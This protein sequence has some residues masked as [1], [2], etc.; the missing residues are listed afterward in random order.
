[1]HRVAILVVLLMGALGVF[2]PEA[3]GQDDPRTLQAVGL[4]NVE[5]AAPA[6]VTAARRAMTGQD[7]IG[8]DGPLAAVGM[9]LALLYHQQQAAGAAGVRA[10]REASR[11][12]PKTRDDES[13][14]RADTRILPPL[15]ADGQLVTVDALA[16]DDPPRLLADLQDLGLESGTTAGNVVSG[17]LPIAAIE[18]AAGLAS[19]RGMTP[20][21]ARLHV[22]SVGSEADTAHAADVARLNTGTDGSGQKVCAL[23]DSYDNGDAATSAADDIRSGDLPGAENPDGNTTPVDVLDDRFDGTEDLPASDEGRAMLQLIHDIAPG[24]NLGFHTAVFGGLAGFASGIRELADAGCTIIVDDIRYASQP[25]YQDGPVT[26]AIDDVATNDGVAYFSSA[27]N[28]GQNSYEAPFRNSGEPGVISTN[29][30]RHDFDPSTS[31]DTRQEIT[32]RDGGTFEIF[33]LQWTDPSAR[34]EGSSGPDTDLDI[35]LVDNDDNIEAMGSNNDNIANGDPSEILEYT[36]DTGSTQTLDLVIEKAAGPDPD[37]VK[38]IYGISNNVPNEPDVVIEEYNVTG[39]TIYGH[40]MA[41]GAMAVAAAPFY[42]TEE[43]CSAFPGNC[44]DERPPPYLEPFSSLGGIPILFDQN[45][46]E[47]SE[48]VR[49]K[50]DVT[51]ADGID[52]TFFGSDIPSNFLNG[53]DTDP[54][55]NFFGTSAAAPNVAAIAALIRQARPG[56][57]PQDVYSRLEATAADVTQ[58]TNEN[59]TLVSIASGRDPWSGHGFVQAELAVPAVD[60]VIDTDLTSSEQ[61]VDASE[62]KINLKWEQIVKDDATLDAFVIQQG[63]FVEGISDRVRLGSN[64]PGVY[65]QTIENLSTGTHRFRIQGVVETSPETDSLVAESYVQVELRA[66]EVNVTAYPNPFRDDLSLSVTF[67]EGQENRQNVRVDVYDLLGRRVA[68]PVF[69]QEIGDS[70][71]LDLSGRLPNALGSGTYFFRVWNEDFAATT[72]AVRVR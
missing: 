24:A 2:L 26:N 19:L 15:S 5:G 9:E 60:V 3:L 42:Y 50:P 18:D 39:P 31:T 16:V 63:Y 49:E 23:S 36:N 37:Q 17:R 7:G 56:L 68:T 46:N 10:R 57:G 22:G 12:R 11:R 61:F 33:P 6:A 55:P 1:M 30:V 29:S 65:N 67:P 62:G 41:E 34:V 38:Y 40:P 48:V 51:G 20:A 35:A 69:S 8:K 58:R 21:Y 13:L 28:D 47:I 32:I 52:N 27:G 64:G 4:L 25:F 54:H 71:S 70:A 45:G 72:K 59:N 66:S 14:R 44:F 53:I 43:Y